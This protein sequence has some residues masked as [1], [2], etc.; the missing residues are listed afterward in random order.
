MQKNCS[1]KLNYLQICLT[2]ALIALV[3]A[4]L[5]SCASSAKND[6]NGTSVQ[7]TQSASNAENADAQNAG[8]TTEKEV[9]I[10]KHVTHVYEFFDFDKDLYLT[11]PVKANEQLVT[12]FIKKIAPSLS[13]FAL[14]QLTSKT[15]TLYF[16]ADI[17][18]AI[19]QDAS[20]SA[21]SK[22]VT[23]EENLKFQFVA[24]GV[25][26]ISYRN[27]LFTNGNGF[28]EVVEEQNGRTYRYYYNKD[29]KFYI[30]I[31][32][33]GFC[34]ADTEYL[35]GMLFARDE[36]LNGKIFI[37]NWT[38]DVQGHLLKQ[39][40]DDAIDWYIASA[41]P[42]VAKVLGSKV[43]LPIAHAFGTMQQVD[44]TSLKQSN[45][46]TLLYTINAHVIM[47][48]KRFVKPNLAM[49][50]KFANELNAEG[51]KDPVVKE[52]A[53]NEIIIEG[54]TVDFQKIVDAFI[55]SK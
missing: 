5:P 25:L 10:A 37:P 40:T 32:V 21:T 26:P 27:L 23:D 46:A 17:P 3:C 44:S 49:L 2:C 19:T 31:P 14:N 45:D 20:T 13:S 36:A 47:L 35:S 6:V 50:K 30:D 39:K 16:A 48:D 7:E 42:L 9:A 1:K 22:E 43:T 33:T 11:L 24:T 34:F 18:T 55:V 29:A 28:S 4:I 15:D 41:K 54:I 38:S 53:D 51:A 8:A 52:G 12:A